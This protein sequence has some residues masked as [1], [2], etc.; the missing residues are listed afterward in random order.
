[1]DG[2]WRRDG[3]EGP[4]RAPGAKAGTVAMRRAA[5]RTGESKWYGPAQPPRDTRADSSCSK[6]TPNCKCVRRQ[7]C[8]C[9]LGVGKDFGVCTQ[10][11]DRGLQRCLISLL[12]QVFVGPSL[13]DAVPGV[14][15]QCLP[16]GVSM[17]QIKPNCRKHKK[18]L[19]TG[20]SVWDP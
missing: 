7:R 19:Q 15:Q 5:A 1:M 4:E 20:E 16:R 11:L 9:D 6:K 14:R 13:P 17:L 10:K 8:R 2:R 3:T 18:E 12:E